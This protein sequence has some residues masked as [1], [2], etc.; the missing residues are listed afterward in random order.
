[1]KRLAENRFRVSR[2]DLDS[3]GRNPA[4]L[5]SQ[6]R[7]LPKYEAGQMIGVQLNNVKEDSLFSKVGIQ[8]G[9]IITSF[10]GIDINSPQESAKVLREFSTAPTFELVVQGADGGERTLTYE[11]QE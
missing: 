5:F 2:E 1:M 10:N 4:A 7:I 8:S 11:V 3:A 9:D 6:A